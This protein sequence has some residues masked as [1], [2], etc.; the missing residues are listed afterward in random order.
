MWVYHAHSRH[1]HVSM[2]VRIAS[3]ISTHPMM[4]TVAHADKHLQPIA[5]TFNP[6]TL[7]KERD[8]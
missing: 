8:S 1:P 5:I 2:H 7:P 6:D 3:H 4:Q